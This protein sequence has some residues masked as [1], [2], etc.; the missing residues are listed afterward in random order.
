MKFAFVFSILL[1]LM[2]SFTVLTCGILG[3]PVLNKHIG[4]KTKPTNAMIFVY[5][6]LARCA[7]RVSGD[8]EGVLGPL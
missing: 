5:S 2:F 6:G 1:T 8:W 7:L 3:I 4:Y